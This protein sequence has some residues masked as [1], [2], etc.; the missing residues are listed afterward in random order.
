MFSN[1]ENITEAA[2]KKIKPCD[3]INGEGTYPCS[4]H[5]LLTR[6]V[7]AMENVS[8]DITNT[9]IAVNSGARSGTVGLQ[10]VFSIE[11]LDENREGPAKRNKYALHVLSDQSGRNGCV[12]HI[13]A[14]GA[15]TADRGGIVRPVSMWSQRMAATFD[16]K[17]AAS[18]IVAELGIQ[19][20]LR[21]VPKMLRRL[22][23]VIAPRSR[24][25][26]LLMEI[27]RKL[28]L[29][30]WGRVGLADTYLSDT[31]SY[32]SVAWAFSKAI[33]NV[34]AVKQVQ[35]LVSVNSIIA[36]HAKKAA[37]KAGVV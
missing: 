28:P 29:V 5:E 1:Y 17:E 10:A 6:I 12:V 15:V 13:G 27:G 32:L 19:H 26:V 25:D 16:P 18:A 20:D 34:T 2:L 9:R 33:S 36:A 4:H 22:N 24:R 31:A 8:Y 21:S 23:S 30:T 7:R 14:V 3:L 37:K 11:Y 35:Y